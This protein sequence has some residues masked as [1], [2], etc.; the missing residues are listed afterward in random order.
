MS[1]YITLSTLYQ[2]LKRKDLTRGQRYEE[3]ERIMR[4]QY[5]KDRRKPIT[6]KGQAII[7]VLAGLILQGDGIVFGLRGSVISS[8]IST[9]YGIAV[10]ALA[11][12]LCIYL[13]ARRK[14]ELPDELSKE[15]MLKA[16]SYAAYA[17]IG[18][19]FLLAIIVNAV[20][21]ISGNSSF[22]IS[23]HQIS[24]VVLF[25]AG[26]YAVVKSS[27]YIWLDRPACDDEEE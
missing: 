18:L 9:L 10:L 3:L 22:V 16:S 27:I 25:L 2:V 21:R 20:G 23:G 6:L 12:C 17:E 15:L 26:F 19:M 8:G 24:G 5:K 7:T 11:L 14:N 13:C 4:E 1:S